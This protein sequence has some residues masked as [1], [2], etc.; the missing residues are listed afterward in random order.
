MLFRE[1]KNGFLRLGIDT[2]GSMLF[3]WRMC[4]P[5]HWWRICWATWQ[6]G[7]FFT[8]LDL[9]E[10]Y[11][12]VWIREADEWKTAFN[13]PLAVSN[14]R[15]SHL[16]YKE[17]HCIYATVQQGATWA[18]VYR[19]P[20][21]PEQYFDLHRDHGQTCEISKGSPRETPC[22]PIVQKVFQIRVLLSSSHHLQTNGENGILEHTSTA[23]LIIN[24]TIGWT[25]FPLWLT[26]IPF[27][28]ALV[29]H[30]SDWPLARIS[31]LCWSCP[32]NL[33]KVHD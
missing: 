28:A 9:R 29:S 6:G 8:K 33:P 30:C 25:S 23:M 31:L 5:Y 4:I 24:R 7:N 32:N 12:R 2:M 16:A 3:V 20:S 17:S 27:T 26:T 14:F 18:F 1:K 15:C 11:Y 10:A 13:F 22:H 19:H 21:I